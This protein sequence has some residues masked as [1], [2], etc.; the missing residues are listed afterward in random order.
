M[1]K[2]LELLGLST[3]FIYAAATYAFFRW[4]DKKASGPATKALTAWLRSVKYDKQQAGSVLLE[5][6]DRLYGYPPFSLRTLARVTIIAI[7]LQ[8]VLLAEFV[9]A[10][11]PLMTNLLTFKIMIPVFITGIVVDFFSVVVV[12]KLLVSL[13]ERPILSLFLGLITGL[14]VIWLVAGLQSVV[15][16]IFAQIQ[17]QLPSNPTCPQDKIEACVREFDRLILKQVEERGIPTLISSLWTTYVQAVLIHAWL[18]LFALSVVGAKA[19]NYFA[20]ATKWMQWF[21]KRGKDHPFEAVG[22]VAA[23]VVFVLAAG[24]QIGMR[25]LWGVP[26]L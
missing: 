16:P 17:Y 14:A 20:G 1:T 6:F 21:I 10:V 19:L 15:F 2:A 23:L 9:P 7:V 12:R 5:A 24:V 11:Y 25:Y 8:A 13:R 18:P 4:L 3:P 22:Y 26:A